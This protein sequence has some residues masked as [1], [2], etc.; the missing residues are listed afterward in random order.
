[1]LTMAHADVYSQA[2][3]RQKHLCVRTYENSV[4]V[5]CYAHGQIDLG[6]ADTLNFYCRKLGTRIPSMFVWV[7]SYFD[8]SSRGDAGVAAKSQG[9]LPSA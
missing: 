1:M 9:S 2:S 4:Q 8:T 5:Y 6:V 3:P 7:T